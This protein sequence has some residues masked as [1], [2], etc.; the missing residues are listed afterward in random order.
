MAMIML[1]F[2]KDAEA[3]RMVE[4]MNRVLKKKYPDEKS[5]QHFLDV[6]RE[7][8]KG[9]KDVPGKELADNIMLFDPQKRRT[10][11]HLL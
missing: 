7:Y 2:V 8:I 3:R 10:Q 4:F 9:L 5:L 6:V 11:F 1:L